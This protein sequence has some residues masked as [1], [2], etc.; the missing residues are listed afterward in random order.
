[1]A[2]SIEELGITQEELI[3]RVVDK[4]CESTLTE[5][6]MDDY[7]DEASY[8]SAFKR[9]LA[10]AVKKCVDTKINEIADAHILP[11]VSEL[12][13]NITIQETNKWGE[14]KGEPVSFIE[15]MTQRADAYL[16]EDVDYEGKSKAESSSYSW[17]KSQTRITQL[18]HKHLHYTIEA[19]MQAAM[20]N[21][22]SAIV[23]GI[24][25]TVKIKLEE[26][27][28]SLKCTATVKN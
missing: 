19:A 3:S 10:D 8:P 20:Q 25:E 22:N 26:L 1:M 7:G 14:K 11:K 12:V 9:R 13:E 21:A 4:I 27:A 16:R 18:V 5:L 6:G 28:R 24:Q 17:S 2:L 23:E 15:Y